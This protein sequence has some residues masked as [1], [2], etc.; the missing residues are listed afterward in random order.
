MD[1]QIMNAA[2]DDSAQR[3]NFWALLMEGILFTPALALFDPATTMPLLVDR[4]TGSSM[5][6]GLLGTLRLVGMWLPSLPVANFV[7]HRERKLPWLIYACLT[8]IP[9]GLLGAAL[10]MAHRMSPAA[11]VALIFIAH[12]LFWLG[13]GSAGL[14]WTDIL[15]KCIPERQRG[16]FFGI[17]QA[18]GS[19]GAF[20]LG[21]FVKWILENDAWAFPTDYGV[22]LIVSFILFM[23]ALISMAL[24]K[25]PPG[26]AYKEAEPFTQ[27]LGRL[28]DYLRKEPMFVQIVAK[29]FLIGFCGLA[30]PFYVVYAKEVLGLP[31]SAAGYFISAQTLGAVIGGPFWGYLG[32]SRGFRAVLGYVGVVQALAPAAA[33]AAALVPGT[34]G[35]LA[36]MITAYVL[37]GMSASGWTV[38]TSSILET[39]PS[40]DCTVYVALANTMQIPLFL[41]PIIG[42][43]LVT[44][45]GYTL[46][47]ILAAVL[48]ALA[49]VKPLPSKA[50]VGSVEA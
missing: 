44:T 23:G 31:A 35:R 20:C 14:I 10:L 3:R 2:K 40:Q 16:R 19:L 41:V 28:P 11:L 18:F 46:V 48:P 30:L 39:V 17:L 12:S 8:R 47:F 9:V 37:L 6:V 32:H 22:V 45:A 4:L 25:E 42:G 27:F 38:S 43:Y 21:F 49:Q 7:K 13:E 29:L 34:G 15:G 50:A 5:L 36:L 26:K 33:L 1:V 24:V